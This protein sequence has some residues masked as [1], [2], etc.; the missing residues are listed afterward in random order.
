MSTI[1]IRDA[2][3]SDLDRIT[4]IYADA[5]TNGTASYEL[6][7]PGFGRGRPTVSS[8]GVRSRWGRR[9]RAAAAAG[10]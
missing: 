7:P 2:A 10:F 9:G 1:A 3:P 6:E 4:G 8:S 5:V